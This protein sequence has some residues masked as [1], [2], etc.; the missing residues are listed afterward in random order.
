MKLLTAEIKKRLPK[1]RSTEN[2]PKDKMVFVTKFFTP[3]AQWTWYVLEGEEQE[4][5]NWIFFGYVSGLESEWGYFD[6]AS[7]QEARG[8]LGM[9]IA[10]DRFF[11]NV[12][13]KNVLPREEWE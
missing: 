13:V 5:G 9:P 11:V 10:R 7:L 8:P 1:L 3:D 4:D 2:I 12:L 6:L